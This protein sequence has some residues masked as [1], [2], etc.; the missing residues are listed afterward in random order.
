MACLD[1]DVLNTADEVEGR[2]GEPTSL[3]ALLQAEQGKLSMRLL[4]NCNSYIGCADN[5]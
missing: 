1:L 2:I 3:H 5:L 4:T